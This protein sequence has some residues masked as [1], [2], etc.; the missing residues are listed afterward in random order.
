MLVMDAFLLIAQ[1]CVMGV[2][3]YK[4]NDFCTADHSETKV[5]CSLACRIVSFLNIGMWSQIGARYGRFLLD[6]DTACS[7]PYLQFCGIA[8][9]AT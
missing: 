3:Q 5:G 6:G 7:M 1:V 4:S 9:H 8:V 2:Y